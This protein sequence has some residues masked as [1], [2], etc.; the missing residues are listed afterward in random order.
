MALA[1]MASNKSTGIDG[2]PLEFYRRCWNLLESDLLDVYHTALSNGRLGTSQWTSGDQ[3]VTQKRR[4]VVPQEL[5]T[6]ITP[7]SRL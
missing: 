4:K 5:A 2:V 3:T 6:N 1:S 7:I